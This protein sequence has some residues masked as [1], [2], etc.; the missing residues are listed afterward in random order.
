MFIP[1]FLFINFLKSLS[2]NVLELNFDK[3]EAESIIIPKKG[4]IVIFPIDQY[5]SVKK[6]NSGVKY[7]LI[8]E[9]LSSFSSQVD[10]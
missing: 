7:V 3:M 8:T 4:K 10:H 9:L 6:V 5:H 2:F 1:F